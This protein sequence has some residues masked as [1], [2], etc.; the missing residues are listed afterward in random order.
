MHESS[1]FSF[2]NMFTCCLFR[3][4]QEKRAFPLLM[5]SIT[6]FTK[7]RQKE[8]GRG[9]N[10]SLKVAVHKSVTSFNLGRKDTLLFWRCSVVMMIAFFVPM[11][12]GV[13]GV[14]FFSYLCRPCCCVSAWEMT[15]VMPAHPSLPPSLRKPDSSPHKT[16]TEPS[17]HPT[18]P[19]S[20]TNPSPPP[21]TTCPCLP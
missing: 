4:M 15:L 7:K 6:R 19:H 17:T 10:I 20:L 18:P 12:A 13:L 21:A 3:L 2:L 11:W 14:C 16:P 9:G 5:L 1:R 8:R